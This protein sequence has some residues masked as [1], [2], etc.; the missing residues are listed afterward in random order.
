MVSR[1]GMDVHLG[2]AVTDIARSKGGKQTVTYNQTM[3]TVGDDGEDVSKAE[4]GKKL[5]VDCVVVRVQAQAS[6]CSCVRAQARA[7][8]RRRLPC[9]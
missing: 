9:S 2:C 4:E 5:E 1:D 3:L 6:A 7:A 8:W